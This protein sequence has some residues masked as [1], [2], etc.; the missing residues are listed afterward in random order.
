MIKEIITDEH[1]L[2][3]PSVICDDPE[4]IDQIVQD[5]L[6]TAEAN[7]L[8]DGKGGEALIAADGILGRCIQHELDHCDGV[9]I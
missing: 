7:K 1:K 8:Q 5:L 9:L 3:V 2:S 4:L 6:D